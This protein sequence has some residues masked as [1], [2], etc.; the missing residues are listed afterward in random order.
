MISAAVRSGEFFKAGQSSIVGFA[1]PVVSGGIFL[2]AHWGAGSQT[3]KSK[4]PVHLFFSVL[5]I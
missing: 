5:T 3:I 1:P 4:V 2:A